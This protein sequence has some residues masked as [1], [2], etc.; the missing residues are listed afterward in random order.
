MESSIFRITPF[1]EQMGPTNRARKEF[2]WERE[3]RHVGDY[4]FSFPNCV[5]A[6]LV[7]EADHKRFGDD[8]VALSDFWQRK[9]RP[10]LD[11]LWG[12]EPML[13]SL[14]GIDPDDMGPFPA[15]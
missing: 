10:L 13:V 6:F 8:L 9:P 12:L 5:V 14:S 2:W 7:P 3:W 4:Q 11:P 1:F 15:S